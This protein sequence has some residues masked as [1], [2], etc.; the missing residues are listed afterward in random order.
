[1]FG[2]AMFLFLSGVKMDPGVITRASKRAFFIGTLS[3]LVP[4]FSIFPIIFHNFNQNDKN[5]TSDHKLKSL[6]L[7]PY[8]A[9][10][11]FPVVS[12]LLSELKILNTELG[13]IGLSSAIISDQLGLI[14][15][16]ISNLIR[17][18]IQ[19][20]G[21]HKDAW[22][23]IACLIG[24]FLLVVFVIRPGMI[25][26]VKLTPEGKTVNQTY[27]YIIM[28]WCLVCISLTRWFD[29]FLLI[30]PYVLGLIVPHGPPLGS[31]LV[32]KFECMVNNLLMPLFICGCALRVS[33]LD[34]DFDNRV[35]FVNACYTA[36]VILA[37]FFACLIP[38]LC[39][40]MPKR[41]SLALAL[42]MCSKG[43]VDLAVFAFLSDLRVLKH[44]SLYI[45]EFGMSIILVN[46]FF[47]NFQ[48]ISMY[49]F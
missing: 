35:V 47:F 41:D 30:T 21:T 7:S 45:F 1:M 20:N 46:D 34:I 12:L 11:S 3:V 25:L 36:V 13:R 37:K 8:F 42:I 14:L 26:M 27:I 28:F 33:A 38:P 4:L 15:T 5:Q 49:L 48:N 22:I 29:Q 24:F 10:T 16:I 2:Y 32:E 18:W 23:Y 40:K 6:F 31:A 9:T 43:V 39:D 19:T 44:L 17:I